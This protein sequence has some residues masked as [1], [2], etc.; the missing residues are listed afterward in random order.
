ML[1]AWSARRR[2]A[3]ATAVA[4]TTAIALYALSPF[5]FLVLASTVAVVFGVRYLV[6]LDRGASLHR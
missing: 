1:G 6:R 4:G 2:Y 5:L 3:V